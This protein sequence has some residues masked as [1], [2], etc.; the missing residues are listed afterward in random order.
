MQYNIYNWKYIRSLGG[1]ILRPR[2]YYKMIKDNL[3]K[4]LPYEPSVRQIIWCYFDYLKYHIKHNV[5]LEVD[6][7]A[8]QMYRKSGFTRKESLASYIRFPWRDSLQAKEKWIIFQ[9][10]REFYREYSAFLNRKWMILDENTSIEEYN[11]FIETCKY[12]IFAKVPVSCGGK[13][14]FHK[15]LNSEVAQKELW[16]LRLLQPLILEERI[17]QCK[18]LYA[19]SNSS[20]NTIRIVTLVDINGNVK[21]ASALLRMGTGDSSV[22]NFSSGG[23]LSAIDIETGVLI[24]LAKDHNGNEYI[25]HPT[26]GKQIIGYKIEDWDKY[27][28]FAISLA[29]KYM[30]VRY[31]GWDIVKTHNGDFCVIEG[32]KDSGI[33][34][35]ECRLL[36]GLRPYYE[37]LLNSDERFNF[38]KFH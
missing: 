34:I 14:V 29:E 6:Y 26:T 27:K 10:K 1:V 23:I 13:D 8:T 36:Y 15:V 2:K 24:S 16:E 25:Y 9:D 12:D 20:V 4:Q 19:F 33:D 7:F 3:K 22:D 30:D 38:D 11:K 18:E 17:T 28:A 21:I 31:V 5:S 32:N 37:A 35:V